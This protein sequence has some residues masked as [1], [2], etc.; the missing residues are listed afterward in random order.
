MV[1]LGA[2]DESSTS[3][4]RYFS[5]EI[6]SNKYNSKNKYFN[7]YLIPNS[8][9]V[10]GGGKAILFNQKD[11][12]SLTNGFRL[13]YGR[14]LAEKRPGYLF[15]ELINTYKANELIK[16]NINPKISYTGIGTIKSLGL[17]INYKIS[18]WL[19]IQIERNQSIQESD[20]NNTFTVNK[21][22]FNNLSINTYISNAVGP[23]DLGQQLKRNDYISGIN[24]SFKY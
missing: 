9:T 3:F 1:S 16:I 19:G 13:S 23:I 12:K 5:S 2:A 10:R 4:S 20:S 24:I 22:P 18:E 14:I 6:I 17:G 7:E 15:G 21:K 8:L 11:G